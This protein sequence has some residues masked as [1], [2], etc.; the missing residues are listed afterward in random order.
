MN[1]SWCVYAPINHEIVLLCIMTMSEISGM[2]IKQHFWPIWCMDKSNS[3]DNINPASNLL[4]DLLLNRLYAFLTRCTSLMCLNW[5]DLHCFHQLN[6]SFRPSQR[7][8]KTLW[9]KSRGHHW[10][11]QSSRTSS[12]SLWYHEIH[13]C[14]S[15]TPLK[16]LT[17]LF[18][19]DMS[20]MSSRH[21][22]DILLCRPSFWLSASCRWDLLPTHTPTLICT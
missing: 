16:W 22:G 1:R 6:S 19:A 11:K 21:V 17:F 10:N 20:E 7:L 3:T 2:S 13:W 14:L 4:V 12:F 5:I 18:V 9:S 15:D 8:Q